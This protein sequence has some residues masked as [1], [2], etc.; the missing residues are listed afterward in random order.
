MTFKQ[1]F[2]FA[3]CSV[4]LVADIA[5]AATVPAN[6]KSVQAKAQ[7]NALALT[8]A[9]V[10]G[11]ASYRIY[12]SHE[13]I[14]GNQGNYDDFQPTTNADTSYTFTSAPL[15]A[16]AIYFGVLA[17]D[18]TG[19][20][21]EGFEVETSVT[22]TA[23]QPSTNMPVIGAS[24]SAPAMTTST[25]SQT[26]QSM[27]STTSTPFAML[28]VESTSSTGVIVAFSKTIK[29]DLVL[30]PS[31]FIITTVSGTVLPITRVEMGAQSALLHTRPQTPGESYT[32][33]LLNAIQAQDGTNLTPSA[34]R[35]WFGGFSNV[36]MGASSSAAS[37]PSSTSYSRSPLNPN[38]PPTQQP[39]VR[40]PQSLQLNAQAQKDGT[41]A[42]SARWVEV[43][44]AQGYVLYTS[45]DGKQ[46][47]KSSIV[48][49]TQNS[50]EYSRVKPGDFWL[51]VAAKD[52]LGNESAGIARAVSLPA[53]GLGLLAV[54]MGA[55]AAAGS[56]FHRKKKVA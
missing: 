19:V 7:G 36:P 51:K 34:P 53:S 6:V 32:L 27:P 28:A 39:V 42:V 33:G 5:T 15:S 11:A 17:V 40:D 52:N 1:K 2:L 56:H 20:E 50:V 3:L 24:S 16:P 9:P 38:P 49:A 31:Y 37:M 48:D 23:S 41:Y 44:G 4:A 26:V 55:G 22:L 10:E 14:L 47:I 25:P 18:A 45:A 43:P 35:V 29:S 54:M 8:W 21:S 12:Y 46:Y 30:N 13:S